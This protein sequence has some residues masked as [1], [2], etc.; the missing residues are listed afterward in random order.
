MLK[1]NMQKSKFLKNSLTLMLG[2]VFSQAIPIA[3]SPILTRIY[4]PSDFGIFALFAS[5]AMLFST[6]ATGR[7]DLAI[8]LP[9]KNSDAVNI[10]MLSIF[11]TTM[12]SLIVLLIIVFFHF[13]IVA[14]FKNKEIDEWLFFIPLTVLFTGVYQSFSV[15]LTR[16]N[17]YNS[18]AAS[19]VVQTGSAATVNLSMGFQ[20]LGAS[21]LISGQLI[22][23][24]IASTYLGYFLLK[25]QNN[26]LKSV[27]KIKIIVMAKKYIRNPKYLLPASVLEV[28]ANQFPIW[29]ISGLFTS[30]LTG[31]Y[32][33]SVRLLS[34][35]MS[36]IGG[37]VAQS[38]YQEF[39]DR[40][41]KKDKAIKQFMLKIWLSMALLGIL[42]ALVVVL[43]GE[44]IFGFIFGEVWKESGK[45]ASVLIVM[46][47]A[48][49]ISSPTS[50][51]MLTLRMEK[52]SFIFGVSSFIYIPVSL[53]LG[54]YLGD[55][56]I[57]FSLLVV[58]ET[59]QIFIYNMIVWRRL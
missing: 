57:G 6:F 25:K 8:M 45:I 43:Y 39:T 21:G 59:I 5:I 34:L 37:A 12:T 16:N 9:K 36:L 4:A 23:Q 17:Y 20:G 26:M 47:Y 27:N 28:S 48:R 13:E 19:N 42:P 3:I 52:L 14:L 10:L 18:V 44:V 40:Y 55:I 2:T 31:F 30:G 46:Y 41:Y 50:S 32:S 24:G 54:Y 29:I 51:A 53:L 11:L 33:L 22:G 56:Y 7:Y 58:C 49:F 35:P 1:N 15:W 38:F